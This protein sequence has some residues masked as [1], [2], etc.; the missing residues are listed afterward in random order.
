[1]DTSEGENGGRKSLLCNEEI[2]KISTI[3]LFCFVTASAFFCHF[4][5]FFV[6]PKYD[7]SKI[8]CLPAFLLQ[9]QAQRLPYTQSALSRDRKEEDV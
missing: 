5:D 2:R 3:K 6:L 7:T 9:P 4:P 1:M 8:I